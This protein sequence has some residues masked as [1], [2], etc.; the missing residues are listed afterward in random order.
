MR[1]RESW[2][3]ETIGFLKK[4]QLGSKVRGGRPAL[5]AG[6][7]SQI[8]CPPSSLRPRGKCPQSCLSWGPAHGDPARPFCSY[9]V[10]GAPHK[11]PV[12]L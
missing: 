2:D 3:F 4:G 1:A 6:C 11:K 8:G 12:H 7:G 9:S 10:Q 5:A